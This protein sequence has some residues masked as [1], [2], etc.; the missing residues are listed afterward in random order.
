MGASGEPAPVQWRVALTSAS[1]VVESCK[2]GCQAS[3]VWRT[4]GGGGLVELCG[5]CGV[6]YSQS[7]RLRCRG[8][9]D[10]KAIACPGTSHGL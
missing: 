8:A 3:G 2:L 7:H 5:N 10:T 1:L 6:F 9:V 4:G